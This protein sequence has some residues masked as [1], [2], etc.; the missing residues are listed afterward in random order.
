MF[1]DVADVVLEAV[2]TF[3]VGA[4]LKSRSN[5][6]PPLDA[7]AGAGAVFDDCAGGPSS[8]LKGSFLT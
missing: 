7:C 8:K 6:P 1:L 4:A 3:A 5:N 2:D